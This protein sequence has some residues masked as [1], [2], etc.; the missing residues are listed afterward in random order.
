MKMLASRRKL[1]LAIGMVSMLGGGLGSAVAQTPDYATAVQKLEAQWGTFE[2]YCLG[3]HNFDDYAGGHDFT[4]YTP[5]D[6]VQDADLFELVLKKMRGSVMP[7]P[8]QKQPSDD[9]RW[10]L[11]G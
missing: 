6:I 4:S 9:Q 11:I 10:Q 7:P 8:S 3:C 5:A 1:T 2:T